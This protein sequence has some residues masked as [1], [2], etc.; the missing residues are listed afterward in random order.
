M[1]RVTLALGLACYVALATG[2][3]PGFEAAACSQ[4][5]PDDDSRGNCPPDCATCVCCP[6]LQAMVVSSD[7]KPLLPIGSS[8]VAERMLAVPQSPEPGEILHVPI[9]LLA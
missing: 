7:M 5:C 4:R 8:E 3:A 2:E 1:I 9:V 6:H